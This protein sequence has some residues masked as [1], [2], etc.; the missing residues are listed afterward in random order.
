MGHVMTYVALLRGIN[1]GRTR[2]VPMADLRRWLG[3]LGYGDVRT[4]L[5][6]GN[7]VFT[8][9]QRPDE[10]VRQIEKRLADELDFDVECVIFT[11]D[12]LRRVVDGNP[13]ATVATN[14]AWYMV[15]FL[16]EAPTRARLADL[17]PDAYH[18]ELF[19][20]GERVIYLWYPG[21][22]HKSKLNKEITH[23]NLGVVATARNWNTVLKLLE[24]SAD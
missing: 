17:A 4:H 5:Q 20:V 23:R 1:L 3:E 2:K 11:H 12:E 8:S 6:S 13:F 22:I 19:H 21:S 18:P 16:S 15:A 10:L 14:P 9:D 7:A 24:L